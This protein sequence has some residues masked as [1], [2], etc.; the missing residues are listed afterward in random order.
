MFFSALSHTNCGG[1]TWSRGLTGEL[2]DSTPRQPLFCFIGSTWSHEGQK[3]F[4]RVTGNLLNPKCS[5]ISS[6]VYFTP[7][8]LKKKCV[9]AA[10]A[11]VY[12]HKVFTG[13]GRCVRQSK[14]RLTLPL[15]D[16]FFF[17]ENQ[18]KSHTCTP[19]LCDLHAAFMCLKVRSIRSLVSKAPPGATAMVSIAN[20]IGESLQQKRAALSRA[21]PIDCRGESICQIQWIQ[22]IL[23]FTV[24]RP[25][26]ASFF[27]GKQYNGELTVD[28]AAV[29]VSL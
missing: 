2:F 12:N 5:L 26:G 25:T 16:F 24:Q 23:N 19:S 17:L 8:Q 10:A 21:G 7:V 18:Q 28:W 4:W 6:S 27:T 3:H 11:A 9:L 1:W 29:T 22:I 13:T 14:M 15:Y 20:R